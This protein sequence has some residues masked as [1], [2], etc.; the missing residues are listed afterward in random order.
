MSSKSDQVFHN[1][2]SSEQKFEYFMLGVS[3][4]L[5]A[6]IGEKYIPQKISFSQNTFELLALIFLVISI[7]A[8]FKRI[9]KNI[10]SQTINFNKL[11]AGE[12]LSSL[13]KAMVV[14]Q[15]QIGEDG[16][17]FNPQKAMVEIK[18]IEEVAMPKYI[19]LTSEI[20][21]KAI[22]LYKTRNWGLV[23]SFI[24]LIVSK[25]VGAYLSKS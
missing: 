10:T 6:Y 4:A 13:K 3:V 7:F 25:I 22:W 12:K 9:E 15:P 23:I 5:F 21:K 14:N 17:I 19:A 2:K 11:H 18:H 24:L 1:L 8:G 20:N 16:Q